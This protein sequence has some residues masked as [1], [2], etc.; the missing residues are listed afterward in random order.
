MSIKG[1][2]IYPVFLGQSFRISLGSSSSLTFHMSSISRSSWL[3]FQNISKI[4]PLLS[5]FNWYHPNPRYYHVLP[6][7]GLLT[8]L[9]QQQSDPF[10]TKPDYIPPLLITFQWLPVTKRTKVKV[11]TLPWMIWS[12]QHS[13]PS[14][15]ASHSTPAMLASLLFL[16]L[17]KY[18]LASRALL[19]L[20]PECFP[21]LPSSLSSFRDFVFL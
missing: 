12:W 15:P 6:W 5:A 13:A 1:T 4:Q 14:P 11:L 19:L 16:K 2:S 9:H 18:T 8:G 21:P 10:K 20:L 7:D 3:Y 17:N